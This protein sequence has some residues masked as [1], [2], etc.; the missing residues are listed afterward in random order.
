MGNQKA[1]FGQVDITFDND[2]TLLARPIQSA[3]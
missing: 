3:A 2:I 1:I